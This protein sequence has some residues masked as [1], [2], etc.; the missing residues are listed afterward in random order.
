VQIYNRPMKF[1]PPSF[2][3]KDPKDLLKDYIK[4]SL[5]S[6]DARVLI[7]A[8]KS[9]KFKEIKDEAIKALQE[10]KEKAEYTGTKQQIQLAID[11]LLGKK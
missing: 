8:S 7:A 5:K 9:G 4:S 3:A 10:A 11:A 6:G 1:N 2:K